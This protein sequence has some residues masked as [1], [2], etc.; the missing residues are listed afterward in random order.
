MALT[1]ESCFARHRGDRSEQQ[2]RVM[3][4]AHPS[5]PGTLLAVL[6]DG[7]GGHSGGAMAAEQVVLKAKQCLEN[8]APEQESARELL[9]T[10]IRE[11]HVVIKLTRFTSEQDP[12]ST[13][14]L[15][16]VQPGRAD[17]AHC[18]DS[19]LYRFRGDQPMDV[20]RDHSLV[21]ELV[22][23][24]RI[25]EQESLTHPQRNVLV[26]CLG[27]ERPPRIDY[28]AAESLADGD[29]FLLCSDGLWPY[30]S[31][32]ELG[33]VLAAYAPREAAEVLIGRARDRC[34]QAGDNVSVAIVKF[35]DP[36]ARQLELDRAKAAVKRREALKRRKAKLDQAGG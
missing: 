27:S 20:S 29:T 32:A 11:A 5:R 16:L 12:H 25:T 4:F 19:R 17:W 1:I 13:A 28:G 24:G 34:R 6:A 22:R 2:D 21:S 15:L 26:S 33:G 3:V 31:P 23:A 8:Y 30:F 35:S 36:E 7:M 18:G 9:G 14:V 10:A